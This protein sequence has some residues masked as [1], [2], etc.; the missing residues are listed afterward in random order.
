MTPENGQQTDSAERRTRH[1]SPNYPGIGLRAAISKIEA[2]YREDK[3][4]AS[5]KM[6]ALR[7]MGFDKA[8]GEAGRVVS[9]LKGFGLIDEID[10]R[11]KL[12]QRAINIVARG[13]NDPQR[14]AALRDAALGPEI[15]RQLL[16][17]Y[18]DTGLPSDQTL[19]SEL[20]ASKG[21]NPNAVDVLV[22][23]FK[24][25][26]KFAGLSDTEMVDLSLDDNT[27]EEAEVPANGGE[28]ME[29]IIDERTTVV[30]PSAPPPVAQ[31]QSLPLPN[32]IATPVGKET[33][34]RVVFARVRFDSDLRKEFVASLKKYLDYLESTL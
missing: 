12:T 6:A 16:K 20:I 5:P 24:D 21:F 31:K 17:E 8:H 14:T 13:D 27:G 30:R 1:R 11:I 7:H 33:D 4:A 3:L 23:D 32:E 34:G 29:S 18:K 19:K 9:A 22:R 28:K 25:T 2:L 10:E 15:Y 26:L